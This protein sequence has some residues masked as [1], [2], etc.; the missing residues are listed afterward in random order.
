MNCPY[1]KRALTEID[2][3]GERLVGHGVQSV[4]LASSRRLFMELPE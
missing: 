3:Y 2:Y 4:E 1:C